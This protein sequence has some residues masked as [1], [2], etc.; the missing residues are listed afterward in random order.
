MKIT[1]AERKRLEEDRLK[2]MMWAEGLKSGFIM[3]RNFQ[4]AANLRDL[5]GLADMS[6]KPKR[7]RRT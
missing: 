4:A 2:I 5:M 7:V 1:K 3:D 6:E